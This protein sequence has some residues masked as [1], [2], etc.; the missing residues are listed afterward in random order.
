M[1]RTFIVALGG[2]TL[3]PEAQEDRARW[4]GRLRQ[5]V[6]S[7]EGEGRRLGLV[8]GGGAPAHSIPCEADQ[9]ARNL[10]KLAFWPPRSSTL[11][12]MN[13]TRGGRRDVCQQ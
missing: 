1:A 5:V 2:S 7:M 13:C 6:L 4:F 12:R 9:M 11:D 3:R 8:V 10:W